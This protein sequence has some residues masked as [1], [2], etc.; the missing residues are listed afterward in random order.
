MGRPRRVVRDTSGQISGEVLAEEDEVLE[1]AEEATQRQAKGADTIAP[2]EAPAEGA[3][4]GAPA[5]PS[6]VTSTRKRGP[7]E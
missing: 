1:A 6:Q 7:P 5:A 3:A 4:S 2:E